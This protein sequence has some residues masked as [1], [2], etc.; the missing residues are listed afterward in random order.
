[1]HPTLRNI[2]AVIVGLFI[3]GIINGLLVTIGPL[4]IPNPPGTDFTTEAGLK[5]SM[6]LMQPKHFIFPFLAHALHCLLG[7]FIACKI[8]VSKHLPI[9][10][11]VGFIVFFA[12]LYMVFILPAPMWFNVLDL[13]GAYIP[14][15]FLGYKLAGK[16]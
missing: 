2:I 9:A 3:G 8:A 14:M 1:M 16:R 12:G 11:I 6:H 4:V 7:A 10:L 13:V 5:A 15:A